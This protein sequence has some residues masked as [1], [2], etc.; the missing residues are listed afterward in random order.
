MK[1]VFVLG[2]AGFIGSHLVDELCRDSS[3]ERV[4]VLDNESMG[5]NLSSD[6]LSDPRCSIAV[7]DCTSPIALFDLIVEFD[8]DT[9]FHLAAN[10][11]IA[12]GSVDSQLD[13]E[14]TFATTAALSAAVTRSRS[15][16]MQI[17]FS[18]TSAIFGEQKEPIS[19]SSKPKPESTYGWMKLAS[20]R[21]L[22][23]VSEIGAVN[24]ILIVRFP[25]VTGA[26]QTHGVVKDLV[27]KFFDLETGWK[28]LGDGSQTKPYIH[29]LAMAKIMK[30]LAEGNEGDGVTKINVAPDDG[31][32]VSEIVETIRAL[33]PFDRTPVYSLTA[34]GWPGDVVRYSYDTAPLH[35]LNINIE[36]SV[37]AVRLSVAEEI[38][39]YVG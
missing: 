19:S 2:G 6:A 7:L 5:N 23:T 17:V 21:L 25:N 13:L 27:R 39:K 34:A 36:P 31:V 28:I 14:S 11:D 4:I 38:S 33:A 10:S 8:P 32:S 35:A 24:R 3:I 37:S 15:R 12:K 9:I 18:S 22:E 20:E 16:G 30:Q 1:T 26:R 29:A